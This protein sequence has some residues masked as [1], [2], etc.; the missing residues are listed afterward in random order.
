MPTWLQAYSTSRVLWVTCVHLLCSPSC[1]SVEAKK[2]E[3]EARKAETPPA[4]DEPM[5]EE[6]KKEG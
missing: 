5:K 1:I 4:Q 2:A 6:A 3:A